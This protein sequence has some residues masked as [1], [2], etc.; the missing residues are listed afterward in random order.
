MSACC[1]VCYQSSK[2]RRSRQQ[3]SA[4]QWIV[5]PVDQAQVSWVL[6]PSTYPLG[7][8]IKRAA[9]RWCSVTLRPA[10]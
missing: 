3:G 2:A 7:P 9:S 8:G 1:R 5:S 4:A 6:L 10:P